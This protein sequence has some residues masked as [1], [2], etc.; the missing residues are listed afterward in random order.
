MIIMIIIMVIIMMIIILI[1][2]TQNKLYTMQFFSVL[3][4]KLHSQF[5][6]SD[7]RTQNSWVSQISQNS[8]KSS[9]SWKRLN[10][11]KKETVPAPGPTPIY[12]RS[13]T[14]MV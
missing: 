9:K 5:P 10:S 3:G 14:S 6:S 1:K 13:M 8:K 7:H 11:Q 4:S 12:K 2:N